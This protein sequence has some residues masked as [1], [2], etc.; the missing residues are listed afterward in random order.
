MKFSSSI[1]TRKTIASLRDRVGATK[2]QLPFDSQ[3]SA[4]APL[5]RVIDRAMGSPGPFSRAVMGGR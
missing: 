1:D 2:G 4:M 5:Q 3:H